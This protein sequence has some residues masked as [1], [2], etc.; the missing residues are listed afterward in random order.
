MRPAVVLNSEE[1]KKILADKFGVEMKDVIKNTYT[2]TVITGKD[3]KEKNEE[4]Q[5]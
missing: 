5:A 4:G 3:E 2:Y 1:V